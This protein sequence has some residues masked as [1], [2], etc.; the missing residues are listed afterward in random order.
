M[1]IN[2]EIKARVRDL[3]GLRKHAEMLSDTPCRV[4]AQEDTFFYAPQGRLKLRKLGPDQGE[5]IYYVR[6]DAAGPKQSNYLLFSTT[7]PASLGAVLEAALG[8]RGV[9]RKQRSL[10]HVG[11]TR[12]HLDEVEGL[13]SF[14]ELEVVLSSEQSEDEGQANAA[15]LMA[16]LGIEETDL[17]EGAYIDLLQGLDGEY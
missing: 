3:E 15:E 2:I 8:V 7:D 11:E 10:Y 13:G 14:V 4:I 16:L 6:E 9:V 17:V 5:L 12:I 1:G